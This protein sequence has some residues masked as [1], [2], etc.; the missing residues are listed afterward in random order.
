MAFIGVSLP[1]TVL[2]HTP[3]GEDERALL[4][5]NG[6]IDRLLALCKNAGVS[7]VEIRNIFPETDKKTVVESFLPILN[8]GMRATVHGIL[9][10]Q[11]PEA[12]MTQLED[13]WNR[14]SSRTVLNL[15]V[16]EY[17][18][19]MTCERL[20]YE[21][22]PLLLEYIQTHRLPV[23]VAL[24]NNR[25]QD[26]KYFLSDAEGI[27]E[28]GKR[29]GPFDCF[30]YCFDMG[31]HYSDCQRFPDR[32]GML[33]PNAFLSRVIHTHIHGI[34]SRDTHHP[35]RE[36]NLPLRE[37]LSLLSAVG[38]DGVY[39]LELDFP[40]IHGKIRLTEAILSSIQVLRNMIDTERYN[41]GANTIPL[42]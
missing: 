12:Q 8:A 25:I 27:A 41:D 19:E 7:S 18:D 6:G 38:Y 22:L 33:P 29:I 14:N 40:K 4:E 3:C 13:I 32:V 24:E 16:V 15:H 17:R 21:R 9:T 26:K 37:Y 36:G 10:E 20:T 2:T 28:I 39:N 35:L 42:A 23:D 1:P 5:E 31:H 11:E 30:G 34:E